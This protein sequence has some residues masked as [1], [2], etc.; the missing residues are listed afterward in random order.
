M[1][2]HACNKRDH[3]NKSFQ[4]PKFRILH[5]DLMDLLLGDAHGLPKFCVYI[6]SSRK[7]VHILFQI[8]R[9]LSPKE[10]LNYCFV[11]Y[12]PIYVHKVLL[13]IQ[14]ILGMMPGA[15]G[16]FHWK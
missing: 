15:K 14:A 13:R 3:T 7:T 11:F 9:G 12:W 2:S 16:K 6:H 1:F 8:L 10:V 5:L 4:V